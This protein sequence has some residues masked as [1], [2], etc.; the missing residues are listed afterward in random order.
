MLMGEGMLV[1][2]NVLVYHGILV[3][4]AVLMH[5]GVLV[6]G[7][8]PM[9]VRGTALMADVVPLLV[10]G[11]GYVIAVGCVRGRRRVGRGMGRPQTAEDRRQGNENRDNRNQKPLTSPVHRISSSVLGPRDTIFRECMPLLDGVRTR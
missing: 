4:V 3:A 11:D 1:G 8:M 9:I 10:R 2:R 5:C 6:G 7:T